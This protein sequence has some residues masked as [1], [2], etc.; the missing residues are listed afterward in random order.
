MQKQKQNK[1]SVLICEDDPGICRLMS[2]LLGD[3]GVTLRIAVDGETALAQIVSAEP[4]LI[5]LD[6]MM[7]RMSGLEIIEWLK[8]HRPELVGRVVVITAA[9]HTTI[10]TLEKEPIGNILRKPF[11]INALRNIVAHYRD[12][13]QGRVALS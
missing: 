5:L 2:V 9:G 4:D 3:T 12:G 6:L 13:G 10:E 11:D 8:T 7:A 1:F